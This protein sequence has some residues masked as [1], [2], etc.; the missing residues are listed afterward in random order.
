[1]SEQERAVFIVDDDAGVL[2]AVVRDLRTR[3]ATDWDIQRA[4]SGAEALG[5]LRTRLNFQGTTLGFSTERS[6]ALWWRVLLRAGS[7][8]G[9]VLV[10]PPG[11]SRELTQLLK[12][13]AD[14]APY[15]PALRRGELALGAN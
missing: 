4:S 14:F 15:L 12:S 10:G 8:V 1:M 5:I 13:G 6:D 7:V 11:S 3:Y 2:S 9:A